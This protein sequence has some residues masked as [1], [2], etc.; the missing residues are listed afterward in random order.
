MTSHFVGECKY[1]ILG[2]E[3][4]WL[5]HCKRVN[6][7]TSSD[8][9]LFR[10][11]YFHSTSLASPPFLCQPNPTSVVPFAAALIC[12]ISIG[13]TCFHSHFITV[14]CSISLLLILAPNLF[15]VYVLGIA[16]HRVRSCF[17]GEKYSP[18][19][20]QAPSKMLWI[21]PSPAT[22]FQQAGATSDKVMPSCL[23]L[24]RKLKIC[25]NHCLVKRS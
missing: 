3:Y 24:I 10:A 4:L 14:L 15:S 25:H 23:K 6:Y 18:D 9:S 12:T 2:C 20:Q 13:G 5:I 21:L 19:L 16:F 8:R 7:W 11:I 1:N 22:G 17:Q